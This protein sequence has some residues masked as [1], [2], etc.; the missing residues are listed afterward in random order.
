MT[1]FLKVSLRKMLDEVGEDKVKNI[2]SDF[3]C[4]KNKDVEN[5]IKN[6]AIE[7]EKH[8][9][10]ATQLIYAS[11]KGTWVLIGY[12]ALAQKTLIVENQAVPKSLKKR[13]KQFAT[14]NS[15][16]K[17]YM[18]PAPLI[19]QLGKNFNN[20]Y[21][22]LITGDELLGMA[23][24]DVKITQQIL[25]GKVVYLECEDIPD[26]VDFYKSNGFVIFDKRFL[27]K[28]ETDIESDYLLQM[29]KYFK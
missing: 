1:G 20:N 27:D 5:F 7:F 24:E 15:D 28:D 2:L 23:I 13:L 22:C 12:Y 6:K 29:L 16:I 26:L 10:S 21:N 11:Y 25:G 4:P 17:R 3:F 19:A 9:W 14:Y 8:G 18:I